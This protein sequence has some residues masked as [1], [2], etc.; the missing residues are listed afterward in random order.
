M[1]TMILALAFTL[2]VAGGPA[3]QFRVA[4]AIPAAPQDAPAT[5]PPASWLPADPA[6]S[7]YREARAALRRN[8]YTQAARLFSELRAKY[9][10]SGYVADAYYW[11]AFALYRTGET[12]KLRR[13]VVLLER[14]SEQHPKASTHNDADA[15]LARVHGELAKRG[16]QNSVI[17]I[18]DAVEP[19]PPPAVPSVNVTE[20]P[21]RPPR[22][23]NVS[24]SASRDRDCDDADDTR[25]MA[26]NALLQMDADRAMPVL[27]KVLA[28]RDEGS[29]C[30]RRKAVFLLAQKAGDRTTTVLLDVI[31]NDP[32]PEVKSSAVFWLSQA[33]ASAAVPALDSILRST[34]DPELR[35][36]A[37]F[38]L[39]QQDSPIARKSLRDIARRTDVPEET[40]AQAIFWLGQQKAPE[41]GE[42]LRSLYSSANSSD[43]KER[44][45]F[46]VAQSNDA[47]ARQWLL[48]I[49]KNQ[50]ENV[51]QRKKALFWFG[52]MKGSAGEL[53][54]LYDQGDREMKE[55]LIFGF[56]QS[57]DRAAID[58]LLDIARNEKD[59][60]LRKK[61]IFWLGQSK[62]PRAIEVLQSVIDQ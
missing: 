41:S 6:D 18:N 14:Q 21:P 35:G 9:P 7:L 61:A 16:D 10:K 40:R 52:Q 36:K 4:P 43:L 58:K 24:R 31:R 42:F 19:P 33:D 57:N 26:L 12:D 49:A 59:P 56:A 20:R 34:N 60:E 38:A 50:N 54:S 1:T 48:G 28:R 8:E 25:M 3:P 27:E 5:M 15:L 39:S 32:D 22:A 46:S 23:P 37:L 45:L 30:L 11:E 62:D 17:Y 53:V 29:V 51:E 44:I 55:Q 2:P 13:A 47:Q